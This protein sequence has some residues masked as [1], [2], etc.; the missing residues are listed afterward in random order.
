V[1]GGR[2][3]AGGVALCNQTTSCVAA[4]SSAA[5]SAGGGLMHPLPPGC[6]VPGEPPPTLPSTRP[7]SGR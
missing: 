1:K 2:L 7:V 4:V 3:R 5:V 6:Q